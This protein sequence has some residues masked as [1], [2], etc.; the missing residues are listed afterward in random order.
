MRRDTGQRTRKQPNVR[1]GVSLSLLTEMMA[2]MYWQSV[3]DN[4]DGFTLAHAILVE[5][6]KE[7]EMVRI[8]GRCFDEK[9]R[10]TGE[11]AIL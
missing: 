6:S 11:E 9:L 2:L 5:H 7:L 4:Q 1:L 8:R 10:A 3:R